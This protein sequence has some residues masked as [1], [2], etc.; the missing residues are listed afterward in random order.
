[1]SAKKIN[2]VYKKLKLSNINFNIILFISF[3]FLSYI[4]N[5]DEIRKLNPERDLAAPA[6]EE[7]NIN[8]KECF[9]NVVKLTQ[10]NYHLNSIGSN[11]R[12]NFLVQY[13][14]YMNN[15]ELKSSRFVYGLTKNGQC[16]FS[17]KFSFSNEYNIEIDEDIFEESYYSNIYLLEDSKNLLVFLKRNIFKKNQYLF[18]INAYDSLVELYDLNND[19]N[20]NYLIWS[21]NSFLN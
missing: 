8:N 7:K 16:F 5:Q 1:M 2:T 13:N 18:S 19:N 10:K 20:N 12:G 17:E 6:F 3:S 14:E 11:M 9:N 15:D 21:F 4:N